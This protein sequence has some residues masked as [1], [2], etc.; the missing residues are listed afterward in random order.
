MATLISLVFVVQDSP[1]FSATAVKDGMEWEGSS[2]DYRADAEA[3]LKQM[4]VSAAAEKQTKPF[5]AQP[6]QCLEVED[7]W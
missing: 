1:T 3:L 4:E 2:P 5:Q 7:T 6:D